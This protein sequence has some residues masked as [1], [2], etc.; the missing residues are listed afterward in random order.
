M[1]FFEYNFNNEDYT[2]VAE[3]GSVSNFHTG[4]GNYIRLTVNGAGIYYASPL[5]SSF[6]IQ[7][8]GSI[9]DVEN[10]TVGGTNGQ[11]NDFKIY[12]NTTDGNLYIKPNEILSSSQTPEGNYTLQ[13]DYL[14]QYQP[15]IN[16]ENDTFI[17]RQISPSR[18]EVRLKL[19]NNSIVENSDFINSLT[20]ELGIDGYNFNHILNLGGGINIPITNYTF[21]NVTNGVDDQS[22]SFCKQHCY[23]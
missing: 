9:T 23:T 2:L 3:S 18:K 5:E 13:T 12:H 21:D 17:I 20:D 10:V 4:A 1:P 7:T 14:N 6:T 15:V 11:F 16:S 8:P 19:L 22:A